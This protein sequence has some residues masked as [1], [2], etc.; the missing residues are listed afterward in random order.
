[1]TTDQRMVMMVSCGSAAECMGIG[2]SRETAAAAAWLVAAPN[3][4]P[5][6]I[7]TP[8]EQEGNKWA[9]VEVKPVE[10]PLLPTVDALVLA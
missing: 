6:G 2:W 5:V 3:S 7:A 9:P 1:M 8:D 10:F 4:A